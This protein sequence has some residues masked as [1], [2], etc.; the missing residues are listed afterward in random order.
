[1]TDL[2]CTINEVASNLSEKEISTTKANADELLKEFAIHG[3][4]KLKMIAW[5][6]K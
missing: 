3:M 1:M 2:E 6:Q 4:A 5:D